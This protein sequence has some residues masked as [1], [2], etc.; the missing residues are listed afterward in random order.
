MKKA[1]LI[2]GTLLCLVIPGCSKKEAGGSGGPVT[3]VVGGWPSGDVGF[4]AALAGF[5]EKY[6]AVKVEFEF[7]DTAAYHQALQTALAAGQGAP[8]VAMIEGAYIAQYRD[9]SALINLLEAPYNAGRYEDRFVGLKFGQAYSSDRTRFA[10]LPWDIGPACYFYR[11][12]I[13]EEAGLPSE[14]EAVAKL[15][16]TWDGMLE[17]A[18][19]VHIPGQRWLLPDVVTMYQEL[20]MN[21]DFYDRNLNLMLDRPGDEECL[22]TVIAIRKEKL[23]MNVNMWAAEA[24]AAFGNGA[25]VSVITGAWY[26]GFLKSDIDPSGAGHWRSTVLPGGLPYANVG[27]SFCAIPRQSKHPQEAWAF[28]EYMLASKEGQNAIFEAVDYFP[29]LKTAWEDPIYEVSDPYF[30]GQKTRALWKQMAAELDKPVYTTM[31]DNS[32]EG[33]MNSTVNAAL[34]EGIEDPA[35]IK[36]RI[37]AEIETATAELKRQ[38]IQTLRDAGVWKN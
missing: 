3:I 13:F 32:A 9:S 10:A 20:F 34:D 19:K 25:L 24:Y 22:K 15:I 4:K 14:P 30:G 2:L 16:S 11:S 37:A 35:V 23:D 12:D 38:Q 26:G 8:D 29:S 7:T 31:M 18:R 5:N 33:V 1:I 17:A 28:M 6:P 36:R 27:G 21:R